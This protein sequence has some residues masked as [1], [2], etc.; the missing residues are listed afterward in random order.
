MDYVA[1]HHTVT[2]NLQEK[3]NI[4]ET[5]FE[6]VEGRPL[7]MWQVGSSWKQTDSQVHLPTVNGQQTVN[8]QNEL[9][10]QSK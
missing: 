10:S 3:K 9:D 8:C 4:K 7:T 6:K 2:L 5:A 1:F